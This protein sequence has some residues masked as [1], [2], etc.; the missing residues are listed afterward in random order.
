MRTE[1]AEAR[2]AQDLQALADPV[3][4]GVLSPI[5]QRTEVSVLDRLVPGHVGVV[6]VALIGL[7]RLLRVHHLADAELLCSSGEAAFAGGAFQA[8]GRD[9]G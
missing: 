4:N 1:L 7:H 5:S 3:A 9:R 8:S 2:S 6:D